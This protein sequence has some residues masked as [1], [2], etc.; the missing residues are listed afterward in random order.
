MKRNLI[1]RFLLILLLSFIN[2]Q[3][4]E[5]KRQFL[6]KKVTKRIDSIKNI[7]K[8]FPLKN[9]YERGEF[10][11]DSEKIK[12]IIEE[13]KFPDSYNFIDK[14]NPT[15][16]IKNQLSCGSCWAFAS[17]TALAYRFKKQGIDVN[18]SPQN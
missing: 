5:E 11:Y 14:E 9:F 10:V 3:M 8:L 2:S 12:K 16:H 1:F 15:V 7:N 6:L 17:S 18:L 13:N 4:T